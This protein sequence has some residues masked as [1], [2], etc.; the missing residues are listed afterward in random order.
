MAWNI[1]TKEQINAA[2]VAIWKGERPDA[3]S[4]RGSDLWLFAL[5]A[6]SI[7]YRLHRSIKRGVD[8]LM[9]DTSFEEYLDRWLVTFGL[10]DGSGG[11]GRIIP[12]ISAATNGLTCTADAGGGGVAANAWQNKTLTDDGNKS[13]ICT[14]AHGAVG[15][16]NSV[17]LDIESVDTGYAVNLESGTTLTWDS[18]PA[19]S[20]DDAT[21]AKD[22][23]G[24]TDL[25]TDTAAVVRLLQRLRTPPL[26]GN[27]ASWVDTIEAV[28]PGNLKAYIWPQREN[29]PYGYCR[30]DYC[31]IY[32]NESGSDRHISASDD[33]YA[34]IETAIENYMPALSF[35][36]SRQLTLSSVFIDVDSTITLGPSATADQ[37]CDWDA[38]SIKTT[39]AGTTYASRVIDCLANVCAP[40]ITNGLEVGHKVVINGYEAEVDAVNITADASIFSVAEWPDGW[41]T[42]ATAMNGLYVLSGGGFIGYK[43]DYD[44]GIEGTGC[45]E[46]IR[47]YMDGRGPNDSYSG[48][49]SKIPGWSSDVKIQGL[50][51]AQLVVGNGVIEDV[52]VAAPAADLSHAS[53]S[54][55]TAL[56]YDVDEI[57]VWQVFV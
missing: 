10:P 45:I 20:E 8:A 47:A 36:N 40:T 39:V 14:E 31:A 15:A 37:K 29:Y 57:R 1:P 9:P 24:G 26:S 6:T 23:T 32:T 28:L 30:T 53:E 13:Y 54:G 5:V 34:D 41:P 35:A 46:A 12:H 22:L 17:D 11:Y 3:D 52:T 48:A 18:P 4:T 49:T 56:I 33:V 51:S 50:E 38:E 2:I 43:T 42:G 27:V 16:G 7:V 44:L 55:T 25:E 21:T 19:G